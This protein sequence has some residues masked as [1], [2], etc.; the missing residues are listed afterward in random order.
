MSSRG[1]KL[2]FHAPMFVNN[3]TEII[4]FLNQLRKKK[5]ETS[6]LAL[7]KQISMHAPD[8]KDLSIEPC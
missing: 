2:H 5:V 6:L 4:K 7:P 8:L 1:G 3:I